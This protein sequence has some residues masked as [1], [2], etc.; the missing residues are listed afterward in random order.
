MFLNCVLSISRSFI[1]KKCF[2][3]IFGEKW[4]KLDQIKKLNERMYLTLIIFGHSKG[5]AVEMFEIFNFHHNDIFAILA[6]IIIKLI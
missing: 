4:T 2:L 3:L 6:V 1:I 5:C